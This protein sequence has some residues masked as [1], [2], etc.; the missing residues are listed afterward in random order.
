MH[1]INMT[2]K[3][4]VPEITVLSMTIIKVFQ[5]RLKLLFAIS[6]IGTMHPVIT[7]PGMVPTLEEPT[8]R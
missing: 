3:S 5:Q 2:N 7:E 6:T 4:P 1:L 8:G